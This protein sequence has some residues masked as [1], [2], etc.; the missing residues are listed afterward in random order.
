MWRLPGDHDEP[1]RPATAPAADQLWRSV[2]APQATDIRHPA[3][4]KLFIESKPLPR[5]NGLLFR[6]RPRSSTE[7]AA[8]LAHSVV[9]SRDETTIVRPRL[10]TNRGRFLGRG[11]LRPT[12]GCSGNWF[13][14]R[15]RGLSGSDLFDQPGSHSA[16]TW[17]TAPGFPDCRSTLRGELPFHNTPLLVVGCDPGSPGTSP[18]ARRSRI[19][20]TGYFQPPVEGFSNPVV[21]IGFPFSCDAH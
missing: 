13:A 1:W 10:E 6:R 11:S 2:L 16:A 21:F 4:N 3:F 14:A 18:G 12:S 5:G 19:E 20:R 7:E 9:T 15:H 8:Y 17:H